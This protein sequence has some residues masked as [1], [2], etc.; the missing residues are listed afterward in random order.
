MLLITGQKTSKWSLEWS[1]INSNSSCL[2]FSTLP[3]LCSLR[4]S[5]LFWLLMKDVWVCV[6]VRWVCVHVWAC[7]VCGQHR[8]GK[9]RGVVFYLQAYLSKDVL[10]RLSAFSQKQDTRKLPALCRP[11]KLTLA[12]IKEFLRSLIFLEARRKRCSI[13]NAFLSTWR[14]NVYHKQHTCPCI[15]FLQSNLI[16]MRIKE[17]IKDQ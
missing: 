1:V 2:T 17:V 9:E 14:K 4:F 11:I 6:C 15:F 13:S 5:F 3:S 16:R 7:N 10:F 8:H 12:F